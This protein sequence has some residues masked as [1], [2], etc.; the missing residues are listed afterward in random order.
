MRCVECGLIF[1]LTDGRWT[2]PGWTLVGDLVGS[3]LII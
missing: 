2:G 1:I 3:D